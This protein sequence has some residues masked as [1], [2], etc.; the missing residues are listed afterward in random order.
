M[1]GH[2]GRS[3]AR[4]FPPGDGKPARC[5]GRDADLRRPRSASTRRRRP[6]STRRSFGRCRLRPTGGPRRSSGSASGPLRR[7]RRWRWSRTR[8]GTACVGE[9]AEVAVGTVYG[10]FVDELGHASAAGRFWASPASS[11][12]REQDPH[13]RVDRDHDHRWVGE[14]TFLCRHSRR[15]WAVAEVEMP[16]GIGT[17]GR[18][19]GPAAVLRRPRR[20]PNLAERLAT[21][22]DDGGRPLECWHW[23]RVTFCIGSRSPAKLRRYRR[24]G[25]V[26][27]AAQTRSLHTSISK[28]REP[29]RS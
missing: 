23:G 6:S 2:R 16:R 22:R 13:L 24:G 7:R 4:V 20:G 25:G 12:L 14:V 3:D 9:G 27:L 19:S 18:N 17:D 29:I 28:I 15:L 10:P 11:Y 1:V 8:T 26:L 5:A 21:P